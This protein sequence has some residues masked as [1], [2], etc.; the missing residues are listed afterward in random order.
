[1]Q[2]VYKNRKNMIILTVFLIVAMLLSLI[3]FQS[4]IFGATTKIEYTIQNDWGSG[5]TV[6]VTIKNI[7][8]SNIDG[9]KI[10][11]I[12]PNEQEITSMWNAN[13][14]QDG[15]SVLVE[16]AGWNNRI[17]SGDSVSFG[18][19][20]IYNGINNEPIDFIL[21]DEDIETTKNISIN[22]ET[23]TAY[24][25]NTP[26]AEYIVTDGNEETDDETYEDVPEEY[27][28]SIEWVWKN[29]ILDENS[30]SRKN[31]NFDQAI[32]GKGTINYIVRWQSSKK[33]T[34]EQRQGIETMISRQ[35]NNWN[36]QLA[37]YDGW[38]YEK[39][40]VKV[41]GWACVNSSQLLDLQDDEIVYT[42][43]IIDSLSN[44]NSDIPEKLPKAPDKLSR[45]EHFTDNNYN[46]P[47]GF[48]KRFNMYLWGTTNFEGG[49]GG[50]WGQRIS[51]D[52]ILE[53]IDLEEAVI[54]EHEIG[55]NYGLTDF[56]EEDDRPPAGFPEKT[57]MWAGNSS[58]I[59]NWDKW[60][61]RYVWT[62][63]KSDTERF[64]IK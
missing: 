1:M 64:P 61:V 20:M 48:D 34:L 44:E 37:N 51:E 50:D 30:V 35:I 3:L 63:L 11:W 23:E 29:R 55:H 60:M 12:F 2:R 10:R 7:D 57:I 26:T 53:S 31:L 54:I 4:T 25:T 58:T 59:T 41:V 43:Y 62:Q 14:T 40:D 16:N 45:F 18:F 33:V 36:D 5:A 56:Y 9:W 21:N 47:G 8:S 27:K 49:A 13:Y 24:E 22:P 39:L 28:E 6:N 15:N 52:Y 19:S 46:Y 42:D 38:P 17:L 32:D